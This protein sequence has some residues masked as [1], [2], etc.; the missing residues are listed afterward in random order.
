MTSAD[1]VGANISEG[2]GRHICQDNQRFV[3]I[4]RGSFN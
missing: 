1:N 4:T 3:K 2:H